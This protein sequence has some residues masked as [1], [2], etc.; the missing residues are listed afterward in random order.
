MT[1]LTY[2]Q[3]VRYAKS[4]YK[5]FT[6]ARDTRY[7]K[8]PAP[9]DRFPEGSVARQIAAAIF[10]QPCGFA[11]PEAAFDTLAQLAVTAFITLEGSDG[12]IDLN[13]DAPGP[14]PG[15]AGP[16]LRLLKA[17]FDLTRGLAAPGSPQEPETPLPDFEAFAD[18]WR[19]A[20]PT[21]AQEDTP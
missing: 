6:T 15:D 12:D 21:P 5:A 2:K 14:A 17:F 8:P 1:Q 4:L 11:A 20:Y 16:H 7:R 3:Q 18:A 10:S 13:A 19:Q 9:A